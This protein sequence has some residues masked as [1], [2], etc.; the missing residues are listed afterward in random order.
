MLKPEGKGFASL[1]CHGNFKDEADANEDGW[2]DVSSNRTILREGV[3][4]EGVA[5]EQ[6]GCLN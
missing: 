6:V 1:I 2:P 4:V 5:C 3:A